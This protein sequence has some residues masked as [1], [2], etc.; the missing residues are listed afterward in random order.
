MLGADLAR[1]AG[2]LVGLSRRH[3]HVDDRE[4]RARARARPRS[5]SSASPACAT[6]SK[7]AVGEQPREALAEEHRVVGDHDAHGISADDA[8]AAARRALDAQAGRRAPRRGRRARAGPSRR[9]SAAPPTPS[10]ATSTTS[11]PSS[12]ARARSSPR[13]AS[14][15][16]DHVGERLAGD[17]V[18]GRLDLGREALVAARPRPRREA[19]SRTA[20]DSSAAARPPSVRIAGWTPRAS[21]RSSATAT[22]SSSTRRAEQ[23]RQLGVAGRQ[24]RLR[25]PSS[26]ASATSRCCAPSWRSRSIRRRSASAAAT[27][28]A[29]DS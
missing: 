2:A 16:L 9:S 8:R 24:L 7:P 14:R 26:S 19:A 3:A 28:R 29:R 23:P 12:P 6:T 27:I 11:V 17:E 13:T 15:V 10:S 5:S 18:G 21:S 25:G 20:S 4:R 1:R 22:C